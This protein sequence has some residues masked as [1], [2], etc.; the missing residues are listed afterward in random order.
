MGFNISKVIPPDYAYIK[1]LQRY[2]KSGFRKSS[3]VKKF[4][5]DMTDKTEKQAM[6]ELGFSRIWDCGKIKWIWKKSS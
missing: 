3:I 6:E 2:H 4:G 5:I 1:S